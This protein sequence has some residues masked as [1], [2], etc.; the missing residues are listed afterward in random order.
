M[1]IAMS[2]FLYRKTLPTPEPE[3]SSYLD[4]MAGAGTPPSEEF[5][6]FVRVEIRKM[7]PDGWDAV[8]YLGAVLSSVLTTS[9]CLQNS[10]G[11]GG[12]RYA[13]LGLSS[14]SWC[15]HEKYVLRC[16]LEDSE[17]KLLPSRVCAVETGGK[18]RVVSTSDVEM[19]ILRPLHTAIYNRLSR[20][21]WLLRGEANPSSFK[22]F[23][24]SPT[25]FF[26][27]G[28]YESATDNLSLPV[29]QSLLQ[30]ILEGTRWVPDHVKK[31]ARES[32]VMDLELVSRGKVVRRVTQRRGQLMGNLLSFPLL[33]VVNYLAFRFFGGVEETRRIPVKINGDDIVFRAPKHI[34]DRWKR[35][36]VGAGL[37]LSEGKTMVNRHY[38]S[39]NS[40][41]FVARGRS[42][43]LI[44]A[45]RATAF[46]FRRP[47]DPVGSLEGRWVRVCRDFPCGKFEASSR[48][49]LF[50]EECSVHRSL[51]AIVD[52]RVGFE[53]FSLVSGSYRPVEKRIMVSLS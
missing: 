27:S 11:K 4:R 46:G 24:F 18:W 33:C 45:I 10:R 35:G 31:M 29:Q 26:V 14:V 23:T 49:G 9:S 22:A 30:G 52:P 19:S 39:L 2:L 3:L 41:L 34:C 5:M 6:S 38:F 43:R 53:V 7:F 36:V 42:V 25:E 1:S 13:V 21:P 32:Q 50:E 51:T 28:D 8:A 40:K 37:T 17:A 44:P 47:D 12:C 20:F 15:S 48:G 16:L